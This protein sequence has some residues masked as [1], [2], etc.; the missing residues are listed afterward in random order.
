MPYN[1]FQRSIVDT[2]G[3]VMPL[4]TVTVRDQDTSALVQLYSDY[5]G[6]TPIGN[7]MTATSEGFARF[8][9]DDGRYQITATSGALSR[10]WEN[11][12]LGMS[13]EYD[14]V[15]AV[16]L[17]LH[18]YVEDSG[19]FLLSGFLPRGLKAAIRDYSSTSDVSAYFQ[20]AVGALI[21]ERGAGVVKLPNGRITIE[22][23]IDIP[24]GISVKG[25][26][27]YATQIRADDCDGFHLD[28]STGFGSTEF[29]HF[30]LFGANGTTRVGIR[31]QG[32]LDTADELY[33]VSLA[34]VSIT[35][36]HKCV[37]MR[38][39]RNG[40]FLRCWFQ[41]CNKAVELLGRNLVMRF[42]QCQMVK[43][44]SNGTTTSGGTAS[45]DNI[46]LDLGLFNFT[47]G[48]G[49]A[50]P[51]GIEFLQS[52]IY[53][54]DIGVKANFAHFVTILHFDFD[55]RVYGLLFT[56]VQ[57]GLTVRDGTIVMQTATALGGI[58]GEGLA[59]T[60]A[61]RPHIDGIHFLGATATNCVGVQIND[62]GNQ[63]Q[64]NVSVTNCYFEGMQQGDIVFN[65]VGGRNVI[66][67]N[68]CT[69]SNPTN[70]IVVL[71]VI[72]GITE[73]DGNVCTKGI[74]AHP[75]SVA[76]GSLKMGR[77]VKDATTLLVGNQYTPTVAST[78]ALT[79]PLGCEV[80]R[81]SGTTTIT[82]I[83]GTGWAS[84]IVVLIFE[85]ALTVTAGSNLSIN[86]NFVTTA[87][88]T[89]TLQYDS[90][91]GVWFELSRSD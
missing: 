16:P 75:A 21:D 77:N 79:L 69:T 2:A 64:N 15:D 58:K 91:G 1:V 37:S 73:V 24:A 46:G 55:V 28:F 29:E 65:N 86:G 76:A 40:H 60:I 54:F 13:I 66:K 82:S 7:P 61:V 51:E 48:G 19:E 14:A 18:D 45:T 90:A 42:V 38:H 56:T 87:G 10:V 89:L 68:V 74:Y 35:D 84:R 88:D 3:N 20:N 62:S 78:A 36:F 44:S 53:G 17:S 67:D 52:Q 85:D 8:Y 71:S 83:V 6:T 63:N 43:G 50:G 33:G 47:A 31:E 4:A 12:V 25:S 34:N 30:Y 27:A 80:F 70:S 39:V 26:N 49:L 81:I 9:V 72:D 22:S 23:A 57:Q 41:N 59:S 11:E 5:A 32:T